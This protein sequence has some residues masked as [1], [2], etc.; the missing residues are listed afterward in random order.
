MS[1][2]PIKQRPI[3][4]S[5]RLAEESLSRYRRIGEVWDD[6]SDDEQKQLVALA[7]KVAAKGRGQ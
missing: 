7:E 6:L 1:D 2:E 3:A 5:R 4:E